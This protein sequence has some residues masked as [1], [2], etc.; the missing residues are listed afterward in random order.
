MDFWEYRMA[1]TVF[2]FGGDL[3]HTNAR[4]KDKTITGGKGANRA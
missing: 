4:Q 1:Q 2:I 3:P